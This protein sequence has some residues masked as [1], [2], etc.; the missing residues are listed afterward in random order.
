MP[1]LDGTGPNSKGPQTGQKQ[2][3]CKNNQDNDNP[4]SPKNNMCPKRKR[5]RDSSGAG[6][7]LNRTNNQ[8]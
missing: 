4:L 3:R 8:R 7:N 2:G 6:K 5:M 1:N